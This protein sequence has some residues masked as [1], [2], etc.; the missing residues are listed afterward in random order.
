[1]YESDSDGIVP[2]EVNLTGRRALDGAYE[3][4]LCCQGHAAG[5]GHLAESSQT[6]P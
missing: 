2:S 1:M 4:H 5:V 6:S 3:V